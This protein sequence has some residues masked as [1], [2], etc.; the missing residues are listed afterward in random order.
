M[1]FKKILCFFIFAVIAGLFTACDSA[2]TDYPYGPVSQGNIEALVLNEGGINQNMGGI[3]VLN[4]DGSVIPDIFREVNHRPL[5]DVAQSITK[6]NGKYFVTL[7]NSKKIEVIDPETF[8]S[9]GTILYTQAGFPRQIVAISPTE[10]IVSDL[11]RQLVRIRTVEPYGEPVRVIPEVKNDENTKTC[12]MLVDKY[13]RVWALMNIREGNR[14]CGIELVCIDPHQEK[15]EVSY[16]LPISEKANPQAGDVIGTITYNR[17]DIDPTLNWI[18][19][20]VKTCKSNTAAGITSVQSVYR[21]NIGTGEFEHYLDLPGIDMM[22]GFSV[23]PQGEVY[24]CDCLDY[25]AQR[26]YIRNYKKDGSIRNFRV[27]IYP[28]QVYFP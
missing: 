7:D 11:E 23:S 28:S 14:V 4:K 5:G 12:R 22:Y 6:I 10:A 25:S 8:G 13:Q 20:N 1:L 24:L 18:Y 19:F 16:T 15:V 17:T 9:V 26:G 3:S 27:G 21:M 2:G